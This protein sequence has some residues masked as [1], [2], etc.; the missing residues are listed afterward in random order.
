MRR[1]PV[2][3]TEME[4]IEPLLEL[5]NPKVAQ[6]SESQKRVS[7]NHR[8]VDPRNRRF[9]NTNEMEV[10]EPFTVFNEPRNQVQSSLNHRKP[11]RSG[12]NPHM[13][14][15]DPLPIKPR[16]NKIVSAEVVEKP[17]VKNDSITGCTNTE[18]SKVEI[19]NEKVIERNDEI[20][21][22]QVE[23]RKEE[24]PTK[25]TNTNQAASLIE[26]M[27]QFRRSQQ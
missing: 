5:K 25:N 11:L 8:V 1:Y 19:D 16:S 12:Y 4:V 21:Q 18:S 20:K 10:I 9:T 17:L 23:I 27:E 24:D 13:E 7:E 26:R 2:K 6:E 14:V 3:S 22:L 15:I